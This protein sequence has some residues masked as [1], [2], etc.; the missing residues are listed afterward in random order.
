M[1]I[2]AKLSWRTMKKSRT[3]TI[4]TVTGVILATAMILAVLIFGL[5][6]QQYMLNYAIRRDGNW[7]FM[8]STCSPEKVQELTADGSVKKATVLR[9]LGY[10]DASFMN[11]EEDLFRHYFYI[12]TMNREAADMLNVKLSQGR[13]PENEKDRN[14]MAEA[15]RDCG[16]RHAGSGRADLDGIAGRGRGMEI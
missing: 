16:S 5:S 14:K 10:G 9:E 15:Y 12:Q 7:H 3:R 6:V 1:N 2:F 13:L 8:E 11:A 4:V